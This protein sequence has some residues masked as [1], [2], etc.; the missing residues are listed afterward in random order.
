MTGGD[1]EECFNKSHAY[2]QESRH[3]DTHQRSPDIA[4]GIISDGHVALHR[5]QGQD[6]HLQGGLI[7][8]RRIENVLQLDQLG[9]DFH[10][11]GHFQVVRLKGRGVMKKRKRLA[12]DFNKKNKQK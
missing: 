2:V 5:V 11:Q 9:S 7:E 3:V 1:R 10:G 4:S 6:E 8:S 12:N